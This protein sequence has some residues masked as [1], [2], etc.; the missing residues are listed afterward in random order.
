MKNILVVAVHP[1]DETL[2][3]GGTLL[4]L[5]S[6]GCAIHWLI[7]TCLYFEEHGKFCTITS[8]DEQIAWHGHFLPGEYSKDIIQRRSKEISL[9][10]KAYSFDSLHELIFPSVFLDQIPLGTII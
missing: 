9:V 10:S 6:E 2:G 4:R 5:K 7:V 1:D 8:K 3:C